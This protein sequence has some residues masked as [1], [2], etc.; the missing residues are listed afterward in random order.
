M[1]ILTSV[2]LGL[3]ASAGLLASQAMAGPAFAYSWLTM[4]KTSAQ[5][6]NAAKSIMSE[7]NYP[8]VRTTRFGITGETSEE[9][10]Y[11][12]CEDVRHVSLV[13]MMRTERPGYGAIDAAVALMQKQLD[14]AQ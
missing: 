11:I 9:T 6:M 14:E 13:L 4:D 2:L 12:N 8:H 10:L 7:K 5:C 1:R 3:V